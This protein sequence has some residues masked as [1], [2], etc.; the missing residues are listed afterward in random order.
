M[1]TIKEIQAAARRIGPHIHRT[2]VLTCSAIDH[3]AG[4]RLFFKCENLQKV[5]A[6]KMR[7]ATN[8]VFSLSDEDAQ[9]GVA[10][11]SSGNHA[12]A[13][14]LAARLRGIDAFVVMPT[15]SP[16]VKRAA[17]AGYGAE[18]IDCQPTLRAREETLDQVV[19]R[20][21]AVFIHPY[22]NEQIIAGQGTAAL[23]LLEEQPN[24]DVVMAPVG[25]GGLLSGT[26]LATHAM[27]PKARVIAAEPC[28]ADDAARS[29][30][31]GHI[32]PSVKPNTVADGL[33]TSLGKLNFPIIQKHVEAIWTVEDEAIIS[34]MRLVW[35]RMK[36]II[37][38][39]SA[40]CLAAVLQHPQ[41]T[42]A[43]NIG[44]IISGGN[45]DLDHLPWLS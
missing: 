37:E 35:E 20:T 19:Q 44:I 26:A 36:I 4:C 15:S 9:R 7:G 25:G 5:G 1:I 2:P 8:A 27:A 16:A 31:A 17:V 45:I 30:K 39:S 18:I 13:L 34:A 38:P 12:Q 33:L 24:L 3:K 29:L 41:E 11:H 28:G 22:D 40:V 21:G 10:T 42:A 43:Q 23:E 14:A 32:I 6:F